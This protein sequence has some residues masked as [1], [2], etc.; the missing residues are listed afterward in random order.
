MLQESGV[1]QGKEGLALYLGNCVGLVALSLSRKGD[2]AVFA[3]EL[4]Q[5]RTSVRINGA[6]TI[7]GSPVGLLS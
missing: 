5:P 7:P 4:E 1:S 2:V 6:G 3:E